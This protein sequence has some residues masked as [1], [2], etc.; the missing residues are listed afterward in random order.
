MTLCL[1]H[2]ANILGHKGVVAG[3]LGKLANQMWFTDQRDIRPSEF[4]EQVNIGSE[5]RPFHFLLTLAQLSFL[6]ANQMWFTDQRDI[7]PSEFNEQVN[8]GSEQ[9]PFQ[10]LLTLV[11]LSLLFV[12]IHGRRIVHAPL[13]R[14]TRC[15]TC[16]KWYNA[17]TVLCSYTHGSCPLFATFYQIRLL[18]LLLFLKSPY[19]VHIHTARAPP[20]PSPP[21][22]TPPT[23]SSRSSYVRDR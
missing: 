4:K 7:R 20:P 14:G 9:R 10:F 19:R 22:H 16:M 6:M 3:A 2:R 18:L 21:S 15:E 12:R 8:I 13:L 23:P 11:Q 17:L 5:Q 1:A